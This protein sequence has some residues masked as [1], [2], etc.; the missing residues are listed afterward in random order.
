MDEIEEISSKASGE[1]TIELQL[2]EMRKKWLDLK[3]EVFPYRE[4]KDKYVIGVVDDIIATLD[5]H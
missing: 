4:Y 1:A 3:F 2:E 5:D